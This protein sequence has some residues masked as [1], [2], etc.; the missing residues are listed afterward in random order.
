M[1]V[2]VSERVPFFNHRM[3]QEGV[4]ISLTLA[5]LL[6]GFQPVRIALLLGIKGVDSPC[7]VAAGHSA[8]DT[9]DCFGNA[10]PKKGR[11]I[12]ANYNDV[13][14]GHPKWWFNK[15]TSPKSP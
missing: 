5:G 4:G 1:L 10:P 14:R 3:I 8:I 12:W 15:G 7:F 9:V 2:L 6:C 11:Y 13:S